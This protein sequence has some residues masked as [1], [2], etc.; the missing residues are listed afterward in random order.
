MGLYEQDFYQ[1][2]QE[3]AALLKAGA[4][5]QI[6]IENLIEEVEDMGKSQ[7]SE[8]LNRLVVLI[9]HLLKCDYQPERM[10]K[11]W[12]L[13]IKEQRLRIHDHISANPSLKSILGTAVTDAYRYARLK[14]ARE[15]RLPLEIFPEDCKYE[16][17]A[18]IND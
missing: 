5:S 8:L 7:K 18:V 3:Q 4:L 16:I 14:A 13:T 9:T 17:D 12:E 10:G 15:T 6:D 11:S 1:W 2:T